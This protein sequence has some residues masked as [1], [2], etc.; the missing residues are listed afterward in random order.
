MRALD[1]AL[2]ALFVSLVR[3]Y[4]DEFNENDKAADFERDHSYVD[5]AIET[6]SQRAAKV[7][8]DKDL[9][10]YVEA[11]LKRRRDDWLARTARSGGENLGY[12]AKRDGTTVPLLTKPGTGRWQKFTCLNS[13]RDVEPMS[14]FILVDDPTDDQDDLEDAV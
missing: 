5:R 13:L 1:R 3:L 4:G 6:I 10:D 14:G 8:G 7:V 9:G 12:R 2:S 11:V